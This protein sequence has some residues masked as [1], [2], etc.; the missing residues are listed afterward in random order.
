MSQA[1]ITMDANQS[2]TA[3]TSELSDALAALDTCHSGASAPTD[4]VA[5]GKLWLDTSAGSPVLNI[6]NNGWKALFTVGSS[7]VTTN[8]SSGTFAT[9]SATTSDLGIMTGTSVSVSGGISGSS[10]NVG[11]GTLTAGA[12]SLGATSVTSLASSGGVT[13]TGASFS[14]TVSV[15][16]GEIQTNQIDNYSGTNITVKAPLVLGANS[17]SCTGVTS[18]SN[19]TITSGA[20]QTNQIDNYSGTDI[21]VQA[22]LDLGSNALACGSVTANGSIYATGNVT[23]YSD[24]RLKSNIETITDAVA[25]TEKLRGT[26]YVMNGEQNIGVIAQ[27]L[28]EV[29][30]ELVFTNDEGMKSVAYGNIVAVLIEAVKE[31]QETIRSFEERIAKLE[32]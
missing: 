13:G 7:A 4:S 16:A 22:P 14:G 21:T 2:G 10:L 5:A 11:S 6:Y 1:T 23:A 12:A 29:L 31:Q 32:K 3:Y 30:P 18:A 24:V 17:M 8:L 26:S 28:E 20:L 25:K 15:T 19:V 27:E 9:L